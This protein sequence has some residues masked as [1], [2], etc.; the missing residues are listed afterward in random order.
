M[1]FGLSDA[2]LLLRSSLREL[3]ARQAPIER[4]RKVME[5]GDGI[6]RALHRALGE[7][8]ITGLLVPEEHGG[9]G[10]GLLDAVVVAQELGRAA[11]PISFHTAYVM[12]PLLLQAA[13]SDAQQHEWLPRIAEGSAVVAVALDAAAL[14]GRTPRTTG[15]APHGGLRVDRGRISGSV[16]FVPDAVGAEVIVLQ[17]GDDLLLLPPDAPGLTIEPLRTVDDTRRVGELILDGVPA[18]SVARLIGGSS[19]AGGAGGRGA[20]EG[21]GVAA[22]RALEAGRV[23]LAADALGAA[24]EGLSLAVE[25]AKQRE[26]F[27]RV[28]GSFQ[29]V[30]HMCA[31]TVAAI[32]PIQSL[33]WYTAYA[34]DR[35]L[36]QARHLVPLLKG[37]ATEAATEAVTTCTQV[38]GG[39]GFTWECDM[40]LYFKRAGYDRQML[41]G[42]AEMFALAAASEY[43]MGAARS[44]IG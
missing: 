33:L 27:G 24:Q 21:L 36:D 29:A 20:S 12:A 2:Q 14:D 22:G 37:H 4:V 19:A 35:G 25:Y 11:A 7:Q 26:Q 6:D 38:F 42:P 8:G 40:H 10:L 1:D 13:A 30:K 31:E 16:A 5:S 18:A 44:R 17:V 32:D 39:I 43:P 34:W 28:I 15:G 9:S 41:G 23:A 3:L